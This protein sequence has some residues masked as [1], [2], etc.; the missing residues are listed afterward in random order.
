MMLGL[1]FYNKVYL[2]CPDAT[3]CTINKI[4]SSP[5]PWVG[6]VTFKGADL[7]NDGCSLFSD[8]NGN[9]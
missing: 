6:L 8:T 3:N 9:Q 1:V 2:D 5:A 4:K 7:H